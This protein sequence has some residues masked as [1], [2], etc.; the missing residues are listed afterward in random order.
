[1]QLSTW[2]EAHTPTSRSLGQ[3]RCC[4][5]QRY[6]ECSKRHLRRSSHN[7][8]DP[9]LQAECIQVHVLG[10]GCKVH[11]HELWSTHH[12]TLRSAACSATH[13]EP[14][15]WHILEA[16][17][18]SATTG[19]CCGSDSI[20]DDRAAKGGHHNRGHTSIHACLC[21]LGC[22]SGRQAGNF[23]GEWSAAPST[24]M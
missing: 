3:P 6:I 15:M 5:H 1:V 11:E 12:I 18:G 14:A 16:G 23:V 10:D 9:R 4:I 8:G 2:S 7:V 17:E 19:R 20:G 21:G 22:C 13:Y 24:H